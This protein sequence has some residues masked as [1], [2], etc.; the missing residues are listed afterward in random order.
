MTAA[1][2]LVVSASRGAPYYVIGAFTA[3]YSRVREL[4]AEPQLA[5]LAWQIVVFS[6]IISAGAGMAADH[7]LGIRVTETFILPIEYAFGDVLLGGAIECLI[8]AAC[9]FLTVL[10]WTYLFGYRD[11]REGVWAASAMATCPAM[12]FS[13]ALSI[14]QLVVGIGFFGLAVT[15]MTYLLV[16]TAIGAIYYQAAL[17]ISYLRA[18][19]LL[20]MSTLIYFVGM[21]LLMFAALL[22]VFFWFGLVTP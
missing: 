17:V 1:P 10:L 20:L 21:I 4:R 8:F 22:L 3:P 9:F 14:G 19:C 7:L 12:F 5:S 6:A 2:E 13:P 11:R 16:S 18:A 15:A